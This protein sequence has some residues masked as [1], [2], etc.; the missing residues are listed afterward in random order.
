[1]T[2]PVGHVWTLRS[3]MEWRQGETLDDFEHDVS[4]GSASAFI[5]LGLIIV[6]AVVLVT[7]IPEDV[8]APWSGRMLWLGLLI[9]LAV[10]F[11]PARWALRRPWEV[12]AEWGDNG[13]GEPEERWTGKVRGVFTVRQAISQAAKTIRHEGH[14]GI[15]GPLQPLIEPVA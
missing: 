12:V 4:V 6:L 13:H 5:L 3:E 2:D 10:L 11:F 14:P 15:E 1:M 9:L 7:T 8:V